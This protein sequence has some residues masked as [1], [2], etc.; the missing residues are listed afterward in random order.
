[1]ASHEFILCCLRRLILYDADYLDNSAFKVYFTHANFNQLS[2]KLAHG[3]KM[4]E[5]SGIGLASN[6]K[7]IYNQ[8]SA[9]NPR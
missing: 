5:I 4:L 7:G 3:R 9:L 2:S 1:V 8:F 6:Q